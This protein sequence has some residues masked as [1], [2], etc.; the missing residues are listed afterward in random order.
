MKRICL[1]LMLPA[2]L[3]SCATPSIHGAIGTARDIGRT[4]AY[5]EGGAWEDAD[6]VAPACSR[7]STLPVKSRQ[8]Y[9]DYYGTM[10][11][12]DASSLR[13]PSRSY[14]WGI[15]NPSP[16]SMAYFAAYVKPNGRYGRFRANIY[17]DGGVKANMTFTFRAD[18]YNGVVL[19]SLAVRP[20]QTRMVDLDISGMRKLYI[21]SQLR[22]NHDTARKIIIGE[23][24]FYTCR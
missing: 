14:R 17:V 21:G 16:L 18:T 7:L 10:L 9:D 3:C 20:G 6:D 8:L 23:P 13:T 11:T 5:A 19:K 15:T 2:L 24:E 12:L 1:A 4:G 22:I